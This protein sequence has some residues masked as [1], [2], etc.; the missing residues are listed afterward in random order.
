MEEKKIQESEYSVN[1]PSILTFN[2]NFYNSAMYLHTYT[3]GDSI[4]RSKKDHYIV[5][6]AKA[7]QICAFSE[8]LMSPNASK[9]LH[10]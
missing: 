9:Y 10:S 4:K 7:T 1:N 2:L 6:G 5:S 3:R 8:S